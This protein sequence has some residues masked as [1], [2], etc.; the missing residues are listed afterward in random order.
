MRQR[1]IILIA[2]TLLIAAALLWWFRPWSPYS[3]SVMVNLFHP[4]HRVENFRHM[5][6][7]FPYR[8]LQAADTPYQFPRHP[9][10]LP[11]HFTYDG[12]TVEVS[13]F[14]RR[15]ETTGLLVLRDGAISV[16][17]YF[18]GANE[19]DR[20]TSWSM[21]KTVVATLIAIAHED[22]H[23]PSLQAPVSEYVPELAGRAWGDVTLHNLLLMASGIAFDELYDVAF[24]DIKM[25]FYRVFL[26]GNSVHG[27]IADLPAGTA[28]G[29]R[30]H[31]ISP[32]TQ[33]LGWVLENA[34]GRPVSEYAQSA[35]W[36]PLG[37]EKDAI[38]SLD[39]SGTELAF[40]CL[41]ATLRDYAKLGLLYLQ[42]GQ[43]Q[44]Q[45]VLPENWVREA[46]QRDEPWLA[47]GNGYSERG[48]GYHLWIPAE[49]D[50]EYFFNG[51]WGQSIWVSEKERVVVVKT[52]VDP[53][54]RPHTAEMIAFMRAVSAWQ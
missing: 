25:L 17:E 36:Q 37:M 16:E 50:Q 30:L 12:R 29:E 5:E 28:Q 9:G 23:I 44:G 4:D 52:S 19:H 18:L 26:L 42:Q 6:R 49:A 15:T 20:F 53:E 46:T 11:Q 33:I 7:V 47:A 21:A 22:G 54:F 48:Y 8:T 24:S 45:Q 2:L 40:C 35:L 39:Q 10:T 43:W 41:N 31:Y 1:H 32:N 38:W 3:P 27:T 13:E 34:V 51:V 14:M